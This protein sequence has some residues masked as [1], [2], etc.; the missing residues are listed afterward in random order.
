SEY[1][2]GQWKRYAIAFVLMAISAACTAIS[3]YLIR[4]FVNAAYLNR[5]FPAVVS[6]GF[7][8]VALF[9]V[10]GASTYGHAVM[11]ARV[12]NR[13]VAEN[14]RRMFA[15]LLNEGLG[16]FSVRHSSEFIARLITGANSVSQVL[17]LLITAI[18]RDFLSLLGL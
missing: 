5:D 13:I 6:L 1:A 9:I 8:T 4:E 11:L 2:L 14:Q 10:K 7:I 12:S 3:A 18:G 15:K 16:F 17:N